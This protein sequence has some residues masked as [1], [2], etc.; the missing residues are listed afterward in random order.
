MTTPSPT[1]WGQAPTTAELEAAYA[2]TASLDPAFAAT[3]RAWWE[4]RTL[5]Q[6]QSQRGYAYNLSN[7]EMYARANYYIDRITGA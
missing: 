2:L 4:S 3:D 1:L 7:E 6:L 5:V